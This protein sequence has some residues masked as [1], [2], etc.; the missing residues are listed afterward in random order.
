MLSAGLPL[1]HDAGSVA[2]YQW[3]SRARPLREIE[4]LLH[5]PICASTMQRISLI[6]TP[7]AITALH[8]YDEQERGPPE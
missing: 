8:K 5:C 1:P 6:H 3:P 7:E 2:E 4:Q